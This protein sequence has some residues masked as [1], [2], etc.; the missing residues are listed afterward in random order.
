MEKISVAEISNVIDK[1]IEELKSQKTNFK[2]LLFIGETG[3]GKSNA[4][5][6]WFENHQEYSQYFLNCAP[7]GHFDKYN[8]FVKDKDSNGKTIYGCVGNNE[9]AY[10]NQKNTVAIIDHINYYTPEQIKA[11]DSIIINRKCLNDTIELDNLKL[12][13]ATAYPET[14]Y[15]FVTNIDYLKK[16]FDIY[17]VCL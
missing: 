7:F 3:I 17:E 11:F 9:V 13:I 4:I 10:L 6:N 8:I 2:N 12:V 14:K 1:T 16:Y 15:Y 5:N